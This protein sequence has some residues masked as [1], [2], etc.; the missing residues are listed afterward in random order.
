MLIKAADQDYDFDESLKLRDL[1]IK[2]R[3]ERLAASDMMPAL[4]LSHV[5]AWMHEAIKQLTLADK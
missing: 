3:D 1:T 2:I 4:V 5:I